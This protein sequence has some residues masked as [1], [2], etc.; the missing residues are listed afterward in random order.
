MR[1]RSFFIV[2]F[3]A[4]INAALWIGA[5]RPISPDASRYP[6]MGLSYNPFQRDQDPLND[7]TLRWDEI[8]RDF[9][10]LKHKTKSVRIYN[11]LGFEEM[12]RIARDNGLTLVG[13]AWLDYDTAKNKIEV[14][15]A[16]KLAGRHHEIKRLI[17]GNETQL[18]KIVPE[19]ELIG[20]LDE[21]RKRLRTPVSTA[22]PWDFWIINPD[23]ADKVDFIAI[24]ILPYWMDISR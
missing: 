3:V 10:I 20:Y 24:H 18:K 4:L 9:A 7:A 1:F 2:L 19:K 13:S 15:A 17:I 11:S 16:I 22:E 8:E 6:F 14:E 12:P 5:N 21:A 23:F